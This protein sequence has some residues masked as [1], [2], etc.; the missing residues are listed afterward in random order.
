MTLSTA[1]LR[2]VRLGPADVDVTPRADGGLLVRSP[3]A[4]AAHLPRIT[5]A[6]DHWAAVA[7]DRVFLA[8]RDGAGPWNTI[9]FGQARAASRR[10]AAG[11]LARDLSP[12]RPILILSA[13]DLGQALLGLGA[14]YAG[15]PFA[16]ISPAYSTISQDFGK[17]RHIVDLLQPGLV[18]AT[19]GMGVAKALAA[20]I[21]AAT[22]IVVTVAPPAGRK[23]ILLADLAATPETAAI[24]E[25]LAAVGPDT[26]AKFLFTSGST[27]NPKGVINT[28]RMMCANMAQNRQ[29]MP[30]VDDQPLVLVDWLPWSHTFGGN[31]NFNLALTQGGTLYIDDGRPLPG[32]IETTVANLREIAPTIYYNVPK[33]FETLLPF[34]QADPALAKNFFSRLQMLF[35]AGASLPQH[36][37]TGYEE[38]A[39]ATTGERIIWFTGLGSTE[40]A[41]SVFNPIGGAERAGV[42]GVPLPGIDVKLVAT[43][44]KLECRLKGPN[45]TPGYWKQPELTRAA[46]DED[47]FYKLGDALK[48]ADTADPKKGFVFDGRVAEDFKLITGTWVSVG[49]LRA[50][51]IAALAPLV[52]DVVIAGPDRGD[53][54]ALLVP[55]LEPARTAA[56]LGPAA[57][58]AEIGQSPRLRAEL[59]RR[60]EILADASKGSSTRIARALVLHEALSID[61]GELTDKGSLNQRAVLKNREGLVAELYATPPGPRVIEAEPRKT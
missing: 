49:P 13:N 23:A 8:Q 48:W 38:L 51:V 57:G 61:D 33:G 17:L 55:D 42:V 29:A 59:Q 41:P 24:D 60:L 2:R 14:M 27:G 36:I 30:F 43:D 1:P 20:V 47:G 31:H 58:P 28:Q 4:L 7:P 26:I 15:I 10:V 21:P 54:T 22:E 16:P 52:R 5:D 18:Y 50:A 32:L 45:I 25:A 37:W 40:T 11:L 12:E 35:Y 53:L 46:F 34:L 9:T 3:H 19:N 39:V 44:G 56:G 6:L